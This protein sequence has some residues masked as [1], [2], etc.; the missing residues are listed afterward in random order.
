MVFLLDLKPK[1]LLLKPNASSELIHSSTA[2]GNRLLCPIPLHWSEIGFWVLLYEFSVQL[3]SI[4]YKINFWFCIYIIYLHYKYVNFICPFH[5]FALPVCSGVLRQEWIS[6]L[7]STMSSWRYRWKC[8]STMT[9]TL[10]CNIFG[11]R[12]DCGLLVQLKV[13]TGWHTVTYRG[14]WM[15]VRWFCLIELN[16]YSNWVREI[17]TPLGPKITPRG[18]LWDTH[19]AFLLRP[20]WFGW[21]CR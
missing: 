18:L 17:I 12:P 8:V 16:G 10:G 1:Y 21:S 6:C 15:F 13:T 14:A 2:G 3:V 9:S 4:C 11:L 19:L 5:T 20:V 7:R